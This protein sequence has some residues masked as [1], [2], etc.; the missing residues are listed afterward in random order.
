MTNNITNNITNCMV[1]GLIAIVLVLF[2][3]YNNPLLE[4][5][6]N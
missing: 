6:T 4:Q 3:Y 5:K 2:L 1:L